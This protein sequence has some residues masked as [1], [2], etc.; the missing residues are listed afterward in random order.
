[1]TTDTAALTPDPQRPD[2]AERLESQIEAWDHEYGDDAIMT[3]PRL[4][5]LADFL[6]ERGVRFATEERS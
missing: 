3:A 4:R 6:A 1:M 2:G 5:E